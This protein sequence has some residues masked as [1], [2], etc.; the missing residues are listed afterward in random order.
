[1]IVGIG[2]D[3]VDV[4]RISKAYIKRETFARRVLTD[5][6]LALFDALQG[7]RKIEFLSG[8]FSAKEAFSKAMGTGI[9][10][11]TFLDIEIM[12]DKLG[13]P[14]V[15]KSPF[16]GSAWVSISHTKAIAIAQVILEDK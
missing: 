9:G 11:I 14:V 3:V 10:K 12:P 6:E 2:L 16:T 13:K 1:M 5:N 7:T 15:T 4:E 8:R